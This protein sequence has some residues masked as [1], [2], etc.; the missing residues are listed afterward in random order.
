MLAAMVSP[1]YR[2]RGTSAS[3][4]HRVA[5]NREAVR[6]ANAAILIQGEH[7][8]RGYLRLGFVLLQGNTSNSMCFVAGSGG[9]EPTDRRAQVVEGTNVVGGRKCAFQSGTSIS[10]FR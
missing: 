7:L 8:D 2:R 4:G 5:W 6:E 9:K 3:L 1:S 10:I